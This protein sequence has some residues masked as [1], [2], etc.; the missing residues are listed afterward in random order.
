MD[1]GLATIDAVGLWVDIEFVDDFTGGELLAFLAILAFFVVVPII[2]I[3]VL[4]GA[5]E[6]ARR[7]AA[8]ELEVKAAVD[9]IEAAAIEKAASD[10]STVEARNPDETDD[11][12]VE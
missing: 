6:F 9:E 11:S 1:P 12:D 8:D 2:A 5:A 3:V 4:A 10:E 7:G